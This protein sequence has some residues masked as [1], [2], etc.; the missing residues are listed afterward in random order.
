VPRGQPAGKCDIGAFE[1]TFM[2]LRY[3]PGLSA[4]VSYFG[5]PNERYVIGYSFDLINWQEVDEPSP[6]GPM[7]WEFPGTALEVFFQ[8]KLLP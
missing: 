2:S 3:T 6:G 5:V 4:V 8:V 1:Q 7:S